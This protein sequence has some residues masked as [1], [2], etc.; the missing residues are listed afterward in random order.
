MKKMRSMA[1]LAVAFVLFSI[2]AAAQGTVQLPAVGLP[3]QPAA[4]TSDDTPLLTAL[5][6][7]AQT[8]EASQ[9]VSPQ[10]QQI[11][12]Q[13]NAAVAQSKGANKEQA[14]SILR[15]LSAAG[16]ATTAGA[17]AAYE[18]ALLLDEVPAV[19]DGL[20]VILEQNP[21]SPYAS[22]AALRIGELASTIDKDDVALQGY[23]TYLARRPQAADARAVQF[24]V[25]DSFR[26][27]KRY[28]EAIAEYQRLIDQAPA[29]P[30]MAPK[31]QDRMAASYMAIGRYDQAIQVIERLLHSFPRYANLPV[32]MLNEGLCL[33]Q[34]GMRKD[35]LLRYGEL[36]RFFPS[37]NEAELAEARMADL[38]RPLMQANAWRAQK[39]PAPQLTPIQSAMTPS[40]A[41]PRPVPPMVNRFSGGTPPAQ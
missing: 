36:K 18:Y 41:A 10:D 6:K 14:K 8:P 35:A 40:V 39:S 23:R 25:A 21:A 1:V 5:Q 2:T 7:V 27:L 34:Q 37:S 32:V 24:R 16:V 26:Q 11:E 4:Q 9:P 17:H 19:L 15:N 12:S 33:E 29:D 28:S 3:P 30:E 22:M 20:R 31:A 13:I 38:K